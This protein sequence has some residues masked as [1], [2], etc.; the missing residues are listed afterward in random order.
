MPVGSLNQRVVSICGLLPNSAPTANVYSLSML[1]GQ[2][3]S[4]TAI[5]VFLPKDLSDAPF[6]GLK[7]P[8]DI[9]VINS[10]VYYSSR[11]LPIVNINDSRSSNVVQVGIKQSNVHTSL[12][13]TSFENKGKFQNWYVNVNNSEQNIIDIGWDGKDYSNNYAQDGQGLGPVWAGDAINN[14]SVASANTYISHLT[15]QNSSNIL[16]TFMTFETTNPSGNTNPR[17]DIVVSNVSTFNVDYSNISYANDLLGFGTNGTVPITDTNDCTITL[18][19]QFNPFVAGSFNGYPDVGVVYDTDNIP[20]IP[21][22][23]TE[24]GGVI[25]P[26]GNPVDTANVMV[27]DLYRQYLPSKVVRSGRLDSVEFSYGASRY[28]PDSNLSL[29]S[30]QYGVYRGNIAGVEMAERKLT[31]ASFVAE[32][33]EGDPSNYIEVYKYFSNVSNTYGNSQMG[34]TMKSFCH[35]VA[36]PHCRRRRRLLVFNPDS[37]L[38]VSSNLTQVGDS[39]EVKFEDYNPI[40]LSITAKV[41]YSS[42]AVSRV[43]QESAVIKLNTQT[44]N[45][46]SDSL[47]RS[48]NIVMYSTHNSGIITGQA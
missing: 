38:S 27:K 15:F 9:P 12:G 45:I 8:G 20:T 1:P 36:T 32:G 17:A 6:V 25:T 47:G 5:G 34:G 2:T 10:G 4:D 41:I 16:N 18:S 7:G 40:D 3:W 14:D 33:N 31:L 35:S 19:S 21:W 26:P 28:A 13:L 30:Y 23:F 48:G 11:N 43:V 24:S 29:D 46:L 39:V 42:S 22:N 37:A 44:F